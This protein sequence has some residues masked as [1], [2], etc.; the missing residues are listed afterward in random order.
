MF[1]MDGAIARRKG[2]EEERRLASEKAQLERIAAFWKTYLSDDSTLE[3]IRFILD[4][5]LGTP[6]Y[7]RPMVVGKHGAV[8]YREPIRMV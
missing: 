2:E 5:F 8:V 1:D 6:V 3:R 7:A 4:R